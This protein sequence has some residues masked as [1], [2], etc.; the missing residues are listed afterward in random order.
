MPTSVYIHLP[1]CEK[2][3]SYCDFCKVLYYEEIVDRYLT[4]LESE[5]KQ[6]YQGEV[7][8]TLYVGGGTPSC[9]SV[10]QLKRFFQ[11]ISIFQ[12]EDSCEFTVEANF[13]S[14][15]KEK[16][17]LFL[18]AGVNRLSF[19]LESTHPKHLQFM[20]RQFDRDHVCEMVDYAKQ[21][22]FS[23]INIDLIYALP[24]QT[25]EEV[26]KDLDFLIQLDVSHISTYSLMIEKNT[27]IGI[28]RI[29]SICDDLDSSMYQ[30]I[31]DILKKSGYFHY[32]I[33]N[34]CKDRTFSRHNMVYWNN[35]EYY[36]FGVGASSYRNQKRMT[37]TRSITQY[38][39][40]KY[41][42]FSEDISKKEEME[43]Q[44]MLNL[45]TKQGISKDKFEQR[46]DKK[47]E[48]CYNYDRLLMDKVLIEENN[49]IFI[50]EEYW[51]VSNEVI[52]FFLEGEVV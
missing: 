11:L 5:I 39:N 25:I 18:E 40:G 42:Y 15:S 28:Q 12:H 48:S 1:F 10:P 45:R 32:E 49:H 9:L 29:E 4:Q 34:F 8:K 14:I 51:Y 46:F 33:S 27:M 52:V 22:G 7:L 50:P 35:Q 17:D 37:N 31:C 23:N 36:G 44:I 24:E 41:T 6:N 38:L 3:C 26:K 47:I 30:F 43:Y 16:L 20:N 19:G 21:I 13:E 2:I